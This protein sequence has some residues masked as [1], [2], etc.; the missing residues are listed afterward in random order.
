MKCEKSG[1][2]LKI[3]CHGFMLVYA[4][5]NSSIGKEFK[6]LF[7]LIA[8]N[9]IHGHNKHESPLFSEILLWHILINGTM[10]CDKNDVLIMYCASKNHEIVESQ[11]ISSKLFAMDSC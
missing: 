2:E 8:V 1:G 10:T 3:T 11:E 4:A 7:I 9:E 6:K 5:L